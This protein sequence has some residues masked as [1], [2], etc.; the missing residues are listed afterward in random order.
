M[1][2]LVGRESALGRPISDRARGRANRLHVLRWPCVARSLPYEAVGGRS[3]VRSTPSM[4]T[5]RSIKARLLRNDQSP[6]IGRAAASAAL[7][8][9]AA[10]S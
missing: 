4:E 3:S 10:I 8:G 9:A 2:E 5:G 1:S 7:L 6:L